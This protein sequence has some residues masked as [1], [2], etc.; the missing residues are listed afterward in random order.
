M[1]AGEV[2]INEKNIKGFILRWSEDESKMNMEHIGVNQSITN[3]DFGDMKKPILKCASCGV[4]HW[5]GH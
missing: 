4:V 2:I 5:E 3:F 1:I